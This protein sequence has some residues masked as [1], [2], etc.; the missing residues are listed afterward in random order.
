VENLADGAGA[1]SLATLTDGELGA[2]L[3]SDGVDQLDREGH[4]VARHNHLD[5]SRK[6]DAAGDI[7]GPEE[8]LR[9]IAV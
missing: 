1:D 6:R 9:T 5:V 8:E 2:L 4:V 3:E 7:G